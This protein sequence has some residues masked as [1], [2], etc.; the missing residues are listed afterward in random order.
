[1]PHLLGEGARG[2]KQAGVLGDAGGMQPLG[3]RW[4]R[5]QTTGTLPL[6]TLPAFSA[7][8]SACLPARLPACTVCLLAG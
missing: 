5:S 6:A 4:M 2:V 3:W 7:F 8:A 1:M